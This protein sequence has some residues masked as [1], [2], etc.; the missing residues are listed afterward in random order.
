[1]NW[2]SFLE[3][4]PKSVVDMAVRMGQIQHQS[5]NEREKVR[6]FFIKYQDRALYATDITH[7]PSANEEEFSDQSE[8]TSRSDW[9]YL[10][11][12]KEIYIDLLD[13]K[14]KGLKLPRPRADKIYTDNALK[15]FDQPLSV[16][17]GITRFHKF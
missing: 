7:S 6:T 11:S 8:S 16:K 1:M 4:Y 14:V 5:G 12:D 15:A 17:L 2:Q 9:C 3:H 10:T 13:K